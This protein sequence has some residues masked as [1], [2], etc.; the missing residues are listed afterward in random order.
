MRSIILSGLAVLLV[1]GC[2]A[3]EGQV[4][5]QQEKEY[6]TGSNIPRKDRAGSGVA[7]GTKEDLE[8]MQNSGGGPIR[9]GS[10]NLPSN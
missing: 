5:P 10:E 3:T 7:V 1:A 4:Q 8:R 9:R 6:V 2:A